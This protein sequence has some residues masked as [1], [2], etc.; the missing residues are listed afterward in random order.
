MK[1]VTAIR[2]FIRFCLF[3]AGCLAQSA[4]CSQTLTLVAGSVCGGPS[5]AT[6]SPGGNPI[7][8]SLCATGPTSI[9]GATI[10]L[11][12]NVGESDMF[13]IASRT[14]G[15]SFDADNA[16]SISFGAN[17]I[18]NPLVIQDLGATNG[19]AV[20]GVS[21][22][23]VATF[24]I[25]P[26]TVAPNNAYT[27][28]TAG[29][30]SLASTS[31]TCGNTTEVQSFSSFTFYK[32]FVGVSRSVANAPDNG[33]A[34]TFTVT[35]NQASN[36]P[37]TVNLSSGVSGTM[38]GVSNTCGSAITIPAN[39][40]TATC[41]ISASNTVQF[42]GPGLAT[43]T[44]N[45]GT[46]YNAAGSGANTASAVIY[47]NDAPIA[48]TDVAKSRKVHGAAGTFDIDIDPSGS[49]I[50]GTAITVEP[51]AAQTGSHKVIFTFNAPVAS[52]GSVMAI[53]QSNVSLPTSFAYSGNQLVATIGTSSTIVPN[54][55]RVLVTV[56]GVN[57]TTLAAKAAVGYLYADVTG[58]RAV[59]G[60]DST[61][62]T[63]RVGQALTSGSARYDI[64]VNG[65]ISST[66]TTQAS[67]SNGTSLP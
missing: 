35:A 2:L 7:T 53:T 39:A 37:T 33:A 36:T 4:A 28:S 19:T 20:P 12:S 57:G 46:G 54:A 52:V 22:V 66:D 32:P 47:D 42:D 34:I 38:T 48:M 6:F 25:T 18:T 16:T 49:M 30:S 10:Q 29:L 9:C 59:N 14:R 67:I 64:T 44:V 58:S 8:V 43:V 23:V 21:G 13:R 31:T 15:A 3:F 51:R 40:T 60:T 62:I 45:A 41:T 27:I 11:Q 1:K 17:T 61:Q 55:N 5:S 50:A 24:L 63:L 26:P 65:A 56:S